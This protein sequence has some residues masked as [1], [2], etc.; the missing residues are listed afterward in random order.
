MGGFS[1]IAGGERWHFEDLRS[2]LACATPLRSGDC[3]AGVAARSET[4][5]VAAQMA[6]AELPL[7]HFLQ[8]A[9]IPYEEDEV[10][11]LIVDSHDAAA[12]A[13]VSHLT[14]GDFRNWL[15]TRLTARLWRHWPR[16]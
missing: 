6:L 15:V 4:E 16:A 1:Q 10:T 14:V 5:R 11:R 2:L 7:S 9:V 13:P 8:E 3:L 12:F